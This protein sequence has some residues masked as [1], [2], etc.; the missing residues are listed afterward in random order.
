MPVGHNDR[1]LGKSILKNWHSYICVLWFVRFL[2]NL[3]LVYLCHGIKWVS[4]GYYLK[5]LIKYFV[6][7]PI[8]LM[9]TH[10]HMWYSLLGAK[11]EYSSYLYQMLS[12]T[13]TVGI[14]MPKYIL[15]RLHTLWVNFFY[16]YVFIY[17]WLPT[18]SVFINTDCNSIYRTGVQVH[19]N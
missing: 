11:K 14:Y 2:R 5:H 3:K 15:S 19:K 12:F 7:L 9:K 4:V 18:F 10:N 13:Q 1:I 17:Y 6:T 16:K 8:I